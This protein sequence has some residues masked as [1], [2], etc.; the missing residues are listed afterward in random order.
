MLPIAHRRAGYQE[1]DQIPSGPKAIVLR[2]A[3]SVT[4]PLAIPLRFQDYL[5]RPVPFF[6][7]I[8]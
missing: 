5:D 2:D 4:L 1:N 7:K 8:S 3:L 6:W